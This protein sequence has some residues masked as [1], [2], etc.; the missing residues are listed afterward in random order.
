MIRSGATFPRRESGCVR[1]RRGGPCG[2]PKLFQRTNPR[3]VEWQVAGFRPRPA[4]PG[5]WKG[6]R[7]SESLRVRIDSHLRFN[8]CIPPRRPPLVLVVVLVLVLDPVVFSFLLL[9][10]L[11]ISSILD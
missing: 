11:F 4:T 8:I 1:S 6:N 7:R 9:N 5:I 10:P 2:R 3:P